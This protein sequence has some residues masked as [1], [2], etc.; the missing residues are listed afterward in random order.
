[1][2]EIFR[3][4]LSPLVGPSVPKFFYMDDIYMGD[5]FFHP[6]SMGPSVPKIFRDDFFTFS[7][8]I[9]AQDIYLDDVYRGD[10]L[11]QG[12]TGPFVPEML[13]ASDCVGPSVPQK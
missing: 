6:S 1:M 10:I 11:H 4:D 3:G 8:T 5:I 2:P 7:G 13:V 9:C 12:S